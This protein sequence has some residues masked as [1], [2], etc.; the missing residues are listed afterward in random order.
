MSWSDY[1]PGSIIRDKGSSLGDF[2]YREFLRGASDEYVRRPLWLFE[3]EQRKAVL[4]E[5][6]RRFGVPDAE[7]D[8]DP[9]YH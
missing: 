5:R 2:L 8:F 1:L 6:A 9:E 3:P 7:L 4:R